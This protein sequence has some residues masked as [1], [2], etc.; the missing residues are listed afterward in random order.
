V[1]DIPK[2]RHRWHHA[3]RSCGSAVGSAPAQKGTRINSRTACNI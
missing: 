2:A 1:R 3:Q